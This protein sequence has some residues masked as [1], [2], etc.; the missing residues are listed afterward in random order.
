MSANL[1]GFDATTVEPSAGFDPLP[2]GEYDF[3]IIDSEMKDTK[4]GDGQYLQLTL[5]CCSEPYKGRL[6]WDLL[7]LKNPNAKAAEIAQR[8]LSAVCRAVGV[9]KPSD[10]AE[11]HGIL[12]RAKVSID[13]GNG[14]HEPSN[15]V[16]TYLPREAARQTSTAAQP[17]A[18]T[19]VVAQVLPAGPM[20]AST[21]APA[22]PA[23]TNVPPWKR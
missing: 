22:Q 6:V 19:T 5:E 3:V 13:K 16:K 21:P 8:T 2:N 1:Q 10:S 18:Q 20:P 23:A 15:R 4:A 7:N 14:G 11:L 12:F 9:L 17:A